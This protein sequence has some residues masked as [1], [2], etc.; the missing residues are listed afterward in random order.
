M[1]AVQRSKVYLDPTIKNSVAQLGT[2]RNTYMFLQLGRKISLVFT[3]PYKYCMYRIRRSTKWLPF[4]HEN[5]KKNCRFLDFDGFFLLSFLFNSSFQ[6]L[7]V[8]MLSFSYFSFNFSF[9]HLILISRYIWPLWK[10][11][12]SCFRS[13]FCKFFRS[14]LLIFNFYFILINELLAA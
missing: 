1:T 13:I 9:S 5:F 8:Y 14:N 4:S 12:T 7:R 3:V 11:N 2:I 10:T 6:L